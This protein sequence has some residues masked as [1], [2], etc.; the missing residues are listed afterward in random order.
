MTSYLNN[1]IFSAYTPSRREYSG[2]RIP[3]H[4]ADLPNIEANRFVGSDL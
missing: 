4:F 2:Q 1:N 3:Q